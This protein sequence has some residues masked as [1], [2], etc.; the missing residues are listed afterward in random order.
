MMFSWH[1]HL[2]IQLSSKIL[3]HFNEC[4]F[5]VAQNKFEI[6]GNIGGTW[7]VTNLN[8]FENIS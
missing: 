4:S 3:S 2:S 8:I 1:M 6:Q 5:W 7:I